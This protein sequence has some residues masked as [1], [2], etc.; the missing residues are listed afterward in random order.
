VATGC[1]LK[2][3]PPNA[4]IVEQVSV[5]AGDAPSLP[6]REVEARIATQPTTH[7]PPFEWL[8]G[9]PV[10]GVFDA[11]TVEYQGFDRFVLQR[12]LERV[13]RYYRARG[14]VEA[15]VTAG[16]VVT[17]EEGRVRVEIVVREGQPV[18]LTKV[19]P[20]AQLLARALERGAEREAL[21]AASAAVGSLVADY[22]ARPVVD[23]PR[24]GDAKSPAC[25]PRPRFDEERYDEVKR[26]MQRVL[27]DAGFAHATVEGAVRIDLQRREAEVRYTAEPGPLCTFGQVTIVGNGEIPEAA[28]RARLGFKPGDRYSTVKLDAAHDELA[29]LGVFGSVEMRAE[30]EQ[31]EGAPKSEVPIVVSLQPVKLRTLKLGIGSL[32]GS[33]VEAHGILGW[34]DRNLLG[35]LRTFAVEVRPGVVM[36]PTRADNLFAKA[37]TDF[38]PQSALLA[39]F[40]QPSFLERRTDLKVE[41][42]GR[43]YAPQIAPAPDPVPEGYNIVGY[44]EL[45]GAVG[46]DRRF[47]FPRLGGSFYAGGFLRTQLDFPFSYNRDALPPEYAPVVI[48]YVDA[49]A[50]WDQ[51]RDRAG[52]PTRTV[53]HR[54]LYAALNAQV[55]FGDARDL[56]FQPEFRIFRPLSD[57]VVVALRWSFGLLFP[58]NY[59]DSL[60]AERLAECNDVVPAPAR[61]SRDLQ[62]LSFRAFYSGGPFS[63]RGYGFREVG[64]HGQLQFATQLGQLAEF[65]PTGGMGAW[66]LSAE[67]RMAIAESLSWVLFIDSSDV[68]RTV[69]DF[70]VDYPHLAPGS[71][72]RLATPVGPL[73]LDVGFRPPYLQRLG[74]FSL[75]IEEGGLAPTQ[76][77][78][79]PWAWSLA[80]GEAF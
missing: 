36:F 25:S 58:F 68:V 15:R 67:V 18:W 29:D 39:A 79:I 73:R 32:L 55:A 50:S 21:L 5:N 70:R 61:C 35:G 69:S 12:D 9:V 54:G 45:N 71:G 53:P 27:A 26:S 8:S 41:L 59:G 4:P 1:T 14:F 52:R 20:P 80:I 62:L 51:R 63:N 72:L 3:P 74:S 22:A 34:E 2:A 7:F 37:P 66:E 28:V 33:Q 76:S 13:E 60:R 78:T 23:L 10:L 30:L 31:G 65:L 11:L 47:R 77:K 64:P 38:V 19:E 40:K 6:A 48:P 75:P 49:I 56:R 46:L 16:R 17:T 43:V 44:Y 42:A 57:R 24:C